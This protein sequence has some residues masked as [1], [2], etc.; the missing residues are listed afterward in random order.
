[1]Q[2]CVLYYFVFVYVNFV[3]TTSVALIAPETN[4]RRPL[5]NVPAVKVVERLMPPLPWSTVV[6]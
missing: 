6:D 4:L 3:Y 5:P 2:K 1:M